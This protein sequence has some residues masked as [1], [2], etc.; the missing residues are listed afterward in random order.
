MLLPCFTVHAVSA[1][2]NRGFYYTDEAI[3]SRF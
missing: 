2:K 1:F 3:R